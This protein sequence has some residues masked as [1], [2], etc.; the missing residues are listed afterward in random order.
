[1][2]K[3]KMNRPQRKTRV[4]E[5]DED[6][7][8][9]AEDNNNNENEEDEEDIGREIPELICR[10]DNDDDLSDDECSV[11]NREEN[12]KTVQIRGGGLGNNNLDLDDE[13]LFFQPS[14]DDANFDE[15]SDEETDNRNEDEPTTEAKKQ[16]VVEVLDA[17][18][19]EAIG[20][21]M[22]TPK[23]PGMIRIS[24]YNP[25]GIKP[26][27]LASQLQHSMDLSIDIQCYSE[28][29]RN[30]LR[31]DQRHIY[32]EGTKAMDRS[33]K[34][35]WGTSLFTTDSKYK[36]GGTAIISR[37]KTAGRVKKSGSDK[38]GRWTYQ[39]LDGQG[40]KDILIVCVYQCCK[41]P[42]NP[43]GHT[44]Y[45]QQEVLLS[46]RDSTDRDPRRNF[47]K[48]I[49]DFITKF[50]S[51]ENSTIIPFIVGDWNEECKGT[52]SSQKLC[53]EFGLVNI[54]TRLYP[55]HKQFKTHIRGSRTIDFALTFPDIA[56]KVT[57]FV[58]E[59]FKYRLKGDHRAFY[60]DIG[61]KQLFGNNKDPV[62]EAEGRTFKSNDKKAV[63][64]YLDAVHSHLDAN[65]VFNRMKKLFE[66]E[67]PNHEEAEI[68]D[69]E[70][71][72]ACQHGSNK[73]QKHQMEYWCIDT[74]EIKRNLSI[75]CQFRARRRRSIRSTA[76]ISRAKE[77]GLNL[78][79][80]MPL[81]IIETEIKRL[82]TK[83]KTIHKKSADR[84][85]EFLLERANISEDTGDKKKAKI[86]RQI[87]KNER[88]ARAFGKLQFQRGR[89][90]K[91]GGITRLQVPKSWPSLEE[92][93]VDQDYSLED[94]KKVD[95]HDTTQWREVNCP[96][97]IEFLLVLRNQ[98]HFGQAET[99]GTPF[100]SENM[101]HKFNWNASSN[102]AELVLEG[103]YEDETISE[104]TRLFLDNMT[105]VTEVDEDIKYITKADFTGKFRAWRES[106]STSPSGR[107]LGHYKTL[108][109][110]IDKT[111][112]EGERTKY[113]SFQEEIAE[114]YITMINYSIKHKYSLKR[115]KTIVNMMIYKEEGN[116][117]IHRLR[118]IH[119]YEADLGFLWGAKWGK[120]MRT[121]VK[122][123]TLHT[124]QYGGL[125]GRDCTSLTYLEELRFD[126]SLLTRQ[127][128]ANFDNDATACYDRILCSIA[129]IA[130]RKYGI[131]KDIIFIHAQTLEEAEFK[132]KI[133]TKMSDKSY[134]H[135]IKFP[136]HG[137]GQGSTNSPTIW[138]FVSSVLFQS[139]DEKAHG[140]L[141]ESP[142]GEMFIRFNMVGFVDD[143]T[144]IT[145]AEK[146]DTLA[147]L[148]SKMTE[149]AQLWHDLLWCSGGKLEL[150]KCGYHVIHYEFDESGIPRMLRSPGESIILKNEQGDDVTVKSKNIYQTRTNLGHK[151][152][153]AG[154]RIG[155]TTTTR[156]KAI[157][158]TEAII[159]C[160]C[161]RSETRMLYDSV[162]KPAIEYTLPQSFLSAKQ[163]TTIEKSSLPKLYAACGFNRN[164]SRAVL[165]GPISLSG[166]GFTPLKVVAG[167]GYVMHFLKNW[168]TKTED[169]GKH[170][171]IVYA[172]TTWQAGISFPLFERPEV[173]IPYLKGSVIPATRKYLS[174][175]E[176]QI[177]LDNTYIRPPLRN[178]DKCI[179]DRTLEMELTTTQMERINCV[180]M[181]LGVTYLSEICNVAG[182]T[183]QRGILTGNIVNTIYNTTLNKAKQK[184]P[185]NRSW[186]MWKRVIDTFTMENNKLIET[187]GAWTTKHSNSGRWESYHSTKDNKVYR[188]GFSKDENRHYWEK[189]KRYGTQLSLESEIAIDEFKPADGI[190]IK[191][192]AFA[193]GKLYG[194]MTT[195][196]E[197]DP[198]T[199]PVHFGP[200]VDWDMFVRAQPAWIHALLADV[201]FYT[202]DDGRPDF[203][204]LI[205]E[206]D[207]HGH[208]I[209]VSDGSVIFHD[210]SFGWV[211]AT[212]DGKRLVGS[213]GPCNGRGNSLRAEGAGLLSVTMFLAIMAQ[214]LEI[215]QIN[216]VC[217]SDNAELI[218]RC[219]AHKQYDDPFPNETLRSEYDIT[220]QIYR[221]QKAY[222]IQSNFQ[223]VKGHQDNNK[224]KAELPLEAQLN[225]EADELAGEFQ[226]S[227]GMFRPI[228]HLLPSCPAMLAI[229]GISVTSNYRKQ[230][231]RAYVEPEYIQYLQYRFE[232]SNDTIGIIAWKS[233]SLAIQRI[234]RN[235]LIT[236]VCNDL[237]PT[238]ATL[239]KQR[240]Q[241]H[242]TCVLCQ[243]EETREHLVRCP[244]D[245]RLRWRR[246]MLQAIRKRLDHLETEFAITETICTALAEWL[247]YG[248]VDVEKY[249]QRFHK[250]IKSQTVVGW[251]H[252]FGG[253]ISRDW[254]LLQEDSN[255]ITT[256]E[257]RASYSWGASI[258]EV[259]LLQVIELWELRNDEVHGKTIE[260]QEQTRK[261]K[262]TVEIKRLNE[263][264]EYARPS[265]VCLFIEEE[266]DY[267]EK[268]TARTMATFISSH[269]RAIIDSVK[270]W[271]KTSQTGATTILRWLGNSNT[272]ETIEKIHTRQRQS[273]LSDGRKK[274]RRRRRKQQQHGRQTSIAGYYT[275][276]RSLN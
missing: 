255:T 245:S 71:T 221:T 61:E 31:T 30:F 91:G 230:L 177:F 11:E 133:S 22:D 237:L 254:L 212:P 107:H 17:E 157:K 211:I 220:E 6:S 128:F 55:E 10:T 57:N 47:F 33:S 156:D 122:E 60:F 19:A 167:T 28:V 135:C 77:V 206:H 104:V 79:E 232:W 93:D 3:E 24:G 242:D 207:Q 134:R 113:R 27:E 190:P 256:K 214:Y 15:S 162:W 25:D 146:N 62:S 29:N 183:L 1:M 67:A 265:D 26:Q 52:S 89:M 185:N 43:G 165:A 246:H 88:E 262:L 64:K 201:H 141:F 117:K 51:H 145:G 241:E 261:T 184:K 50:L 82:H 20:G 233:L 197:T 32:F 97:E 42:T 225:I 268:S 69:S 78:D 66:S 41:R 59:P 218:R 178:N 203:F 92:Y 234:Q 168:R 65:N 84:R 209:S 187:L 53:N 38:L 244:A 169:I 100:T 95:Q 208:L 13:D 227:E 175:I 180:R 194:E 37:G 2:M 58:Y 274:E 193:N 90:N 7:L 170:I 239:Y 21:T 179:M 213:K 99:D 276:H 8:A 54:F 49:K 173:E 164:T 238:A 81:E 139:H 198:L 159:N 44:A 127:S 39:L 243:R 63:I 35:V 125:P 236:K 72:R 18:E 36:P 160:G 210:M 155:Q 129:S 85:D 161:S 172:W 260:Q 240:Y 70:L 217:I 257:K 273:L 154:S 204:E 46:E 199:D 202:T 176:G 126:Y 235:V 223:W 83:L 74:H 119:L 269:R 136:I 111:L 132:L 181:F 34:A 147:D 253:K 114:C 110:T 73:C 140:M 120:A 219:T 270:K 143:S 272:A 123:K 138:C 191:I 228:V 249:P 163:L 124:G 189:Y 150:P 137:T 131:H 149:D 186:L 229:R 12:D 151:K 226:T 94:P 267:L 16:T 105:R 76:L 247:E 251:R 248:T 40:E 130:G 196:M 142:D 195:T 118:V 9:S 112:E 171:R 86:I 5:E 200:M 224:T 87:R 153:P 216:M 80:E 101:K 98:R 275:L 259:T 116:V 215:E 152:S 103:E 96:K 4:Y 144:C 231:I 182:D 166:G 258:I 148:V 108:V 48:D 188:Y 56:D 192:N 222:N 109:V 45:H 158:L 250:A 205:H 264:R 75:W 23:L 68:L 252:F 14:D 174:D 263:M 106:T 102:E 121:A 266:E 271:A 115:W